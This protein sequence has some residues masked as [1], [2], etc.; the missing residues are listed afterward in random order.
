[1]K[2]VITP[3]GTSLLMNYKDENKNMIE[4]DLRTLQDH[5]RQDKPAREWENCSSAIKKIKEKVTPWT[6]K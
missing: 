2:K 5:N 3:V 4:A 6:E 1:M